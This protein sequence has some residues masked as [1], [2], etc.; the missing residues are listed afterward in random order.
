M[1]L[2]SKLGLFGLAKQS[3]KGTQVSPPVYA[4]GLS[5]GNTVGLARD[6]AAHGV[7]SGLR[8]SAN[9][10]VSGAHPGATPQSPAYVKS[11]GA[12]LLGVFG[13]DTVTGASPPYIHTFSTSSLPWYSLFGSLGGAEYLSLTDAKCASLK[14]SW[15]GD[16]PL[17][18]DSTWQALG[19]SP[20]QAS[21]TPTNSLDESAAFLVPIGGTFN[22]DAAGASASATVISGDLTMTNALDEQIASGSILPAV[23]QEGDQEFA[24]TLTVIPDDL[25]QWRKAVTG[26]GTGTTVSQTPVYGTLSLIFQEAAGGAGTLAVTAARVL[27]DAAYPTPDTAG[28]AVQLPWAGIPLHVA[29][30]ADAPLKFVLTNTVA[31]Y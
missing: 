15:T 12:Y 4:H 5:G 31:T 25:A 2:D 19:A 30:S 24:A 7:S 14:L 18:Q 16:E 9:A 20:G 13:A 3:V 21:F 23:M 28:A 1:P 10:L 8:T 27:W 29:A 11:L 26:T 6:I 22:F 17:M